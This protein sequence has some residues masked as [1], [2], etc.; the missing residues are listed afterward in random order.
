MTWAA[1]LLRQVKF[2]N[3][4]FW[5]NPAAAAF[6]FAFP[7]MFL[8]IFNLAFGDNEVPGPD[9]PVNAATSF[10]I[11][12][13]TAFAVINA[14]YTNIAISVTFARDQGVLKRVKGTPLP[15]WIYL[16]GRIVH[17]VFIA[18]IL[19]V[20]V[21]LAGKLFYN[22]DLP[23]TWP[24]FL[25]SL[26]VGAAAF[27][28]LGLALTGFIP[29]ADSSPAI[30]NFSILPLLFISDIFI[31]I[32]DPP[33]WLEA[34]ARFF[35]VKHFFE[36]MQTSFSPFTTGNGFEWGDLGIMGAWAIAGLSIAMRRFSWEPR[37]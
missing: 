19:V 25:F 7:L 23:S 6:T 20:I 1:L 22:V 13:I 34:V 8:M 35:P 27:S 21:V 33:G 4:S 16:A 14:C 30:V 5:R 31:Q 29:N 10:I 24:A 12:A 15:D 9:G 26:V 18:M 28:A 37:R 36:A 11:P 32:D 3:R 2:E 17:A